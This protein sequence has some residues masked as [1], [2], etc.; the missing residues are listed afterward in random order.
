V[1]ER[2]PET[3]RRVH[4]N[5]QAV[6]RV[7]WFRVRRRR[8]GADVESQRD[9]HAAT[10]VLRVAAITGASGGIGAAVA[11]ALAR[12][13]ATL[14]LLG[15]DP[16]RL[17]RTV[18]RVGPH[19]SATAHAL[20]ISEDAAIAS[21]ADNLADEVGDLDALVHCAGVLEAGRLEES[22]AEDFD[23]QYAVNV[24]A[25]YLLTQRLL[26]LLVHA[27]GQVVFV[28]STAGQA[29]S[30][31][32]IAQY[33]ATKHALKALADALR[34]ELNPRGVRV[35]S[36]FLG[37]VA[38]PLQE[39]TFMREGRA[40]DAASLLQPEDVATMIMAALMLPRTGEVTEMTLRPMVKSY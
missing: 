29:A 34:A 40:Y 30:R 15:R 3:A 7:L 13:G 14:H 39:R 19:A 22:K 37:R 32:E 35:L 17:R 4:G 1:R 12:A 26:P 27:R 10:R 36:I 6:D 20:D 31:P 9:E 21:F 8:L 25:P 33:A 2:L 16:A 24:R 5:L 38:T 28:N 11:I 18:E 23:R